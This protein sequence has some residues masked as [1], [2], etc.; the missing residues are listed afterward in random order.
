MFKCLGISVD[1]VNDYIQDISLIKQYFY[2]YKIL[3]FVVFT[4]NINHNTYVDTAILP[5]FYRKYYNG[6]IVFTDT[7]DLL[8]NR[9]FCIN[10]PIIYTKQNINHFIAN[11][12]YVLH[13]DQSTNQLTLLDY[14][15]LQQSF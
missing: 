13:N 6:T 4:N 2:E 9:N 3:D 11:T 14:E 5:K 10:R 15:K 12:N 7:G 8:K 1:N